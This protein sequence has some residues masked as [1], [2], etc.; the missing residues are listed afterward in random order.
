[1]GASSGPNLSRTRI[2]F[3]V[4][5]ANPRSYPGYG[6][7]WADLSGNSLNATGNVNYGGT[8]QYLMFVK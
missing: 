8:W 4:D 7:V 6:A 3:I 1:M 5:T 2:V